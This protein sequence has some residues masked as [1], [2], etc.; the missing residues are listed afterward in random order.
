MLAG[1]K[2]IV[3]EKHVRR[4]TW[5]VPLSLTKKKSYSLQLNSKGVSICSFRVKSQWHPTCRLNETHC[6]NIMCASSSPWDEKLINIVFPP[7]WRSR[8]ILIWRSICL[9]CSINCPQNVP[10]SLN[11]RTF[12]AMAQW[13][14]RGSKSMSFKDERLNATDD[15]SGRLLS[16]FFLRYILNDLN[17]HH[18]KKGRMLNVVSSRFAFQ[19]CW[20]HYRSGHCMPFAVL[21]CWWFGSLAEFWF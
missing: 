12:L 3:Q 9:D 13:P 11:K 5:V 18:V 4:R 20:R 1:C 7:S 2:C 6:S 21:W 14:L 16:P 15:A 10:V 8:N 19:G 17:S